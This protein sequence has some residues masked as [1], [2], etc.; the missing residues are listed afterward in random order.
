MRPK[1][2]MDCL[3]AIGRQR[4]HDDVRNFAALRS[5]PLANLRDYR[6]CGLD[7]RNHSSLVGNVNL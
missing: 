2:C 7:A 5:H 1:E 6:K 4:R 3:I